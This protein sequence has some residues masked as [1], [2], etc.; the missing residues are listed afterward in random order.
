MSCPI[1]GCEIT[2]ERCHPRTISR[3][4]RQYEREEEEEEAEETEES[5]PTYGERLEVGFDGSEGN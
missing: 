4:D 3:L 5:E 1:C 2:C